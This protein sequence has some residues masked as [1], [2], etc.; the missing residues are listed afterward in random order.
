MNPVIYLT[1]AP[2]TG[3]STLCRNLKRAV[4][5]LAVFAYSE[6]LRTHVAQRAGLAQLSEN[7]IRSQSA[8]LVTRDDVTAVDAQLR[9][10]VAE[11]RATQPIV[12]D[13]HPVT[14]E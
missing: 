7:E 11:R 14:K 1:G 6:E 12:I 3:K 13:S 4:P 10:F 2:A 5:S 9:A 8:Q